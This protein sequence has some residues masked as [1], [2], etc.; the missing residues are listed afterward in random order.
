VPTPKGD[1]DDEASRE[2][3]PRVLALVAAHTHIAQAAIHCVRHRRFVREVVVGS[4][5]DPPQQ[6]ALL[7]VGPDGSGAPALRLRTIPAVAREDR[8]CGGEP[9]VPALECQQLVAKL[10]QEPACRPLFRADDRRLA[11]DCQVLERPLSLTDRLRAIE[12]S[13]GPTTPEEIKT[14]QVTRSRHLFACVCR[15]GACA[16]PP[17]VTDL[18]NDAAQTQFL[19]DLMKQKAQEKTG[20]PSAGQRWERE[21]ACLS[22]AASAVQ[23][24]KSAGMEMADGLRCAFDD[25]T[26]PAAKEYVAVLETEACR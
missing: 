14:A 26:L 8:T 20:G 18:E 1:H 19:L 7:T 17:A 23:A 2:V 4:T 9:A 10:Q 22:W 13:A 15:G 5:I 21:L 3:P 25:P 24:H 6:A 12:T 11:P 16:A